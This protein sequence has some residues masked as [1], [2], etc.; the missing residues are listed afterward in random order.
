MRIPAVFRIGGIKAILRKQLALELFDFKVPTR[1]DAR[2]PTNQDID[3]AVN[4]AL[5]A[6][7]GKSA[8]GET[9]KVNVVE[10]ISGFM[11]DM[12]WDLTVPGQHYSGLSNQQLLEILAGQGRDFAEDTDELRK[13]VS[14][15]LRSKFRKVWDPDEAGS[16]AQD[17]ILAW[18]VDRFESQGPDI[19]LTPLSIN[20]AA[21][22][23]AKGLDSRIGIAQGRLLRAV[24]KARITITFR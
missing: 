10:E 9:T 12:E 17:A 22:K 13:H 23:A 1:E 3:A 2:K 20:Y 11:R 6:R 4:K 5:E 14:D 21:W 7:F 8:E 19:S 15:V 16:V 18:I 24:R